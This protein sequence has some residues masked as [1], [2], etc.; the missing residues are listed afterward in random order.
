MIEAYRPIRAPLALAGALSLAACAQESEPEPAPLDTAAV[1]ERSGAIARSFTAATGLPPALVP[2]QAFALPHA[3]RAGERPFCALAGRD[4][5]RSCACF[6]HQLNL[7]RLESGEPVTRTCW[8]G[9]LD[10]V[11]AVRLGDRRLGFLKTGQ[12]RAR[13]EPEPELPRSWPAP[14]RQ[15]LIEAWYR[16]PAVDPA[17]YQAWLSMLATF[18]GQLGRE[19]HRQL[20]ARRS[21]R[22]PLVERARA[23]IDGHLAEPIRLGDVARAVNSSPYHLSRTFR[24]ATGMTFMQYLTRG[25]IERACGLLLDPGRRVAEVA[26]SCGFQSLSQ[27]NRAFRGVIGQTPTAFRRATLI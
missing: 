12:V 4:P 20:M 26:F 22:S 15:A 21:G 13:G 14:R 17:V 27:F 11:V 25:R 6:H 16:I 23:F 18:A 24:R 10:S 8:G 5:D 2:E 19:A 7:E 1:A 3:G 9:L